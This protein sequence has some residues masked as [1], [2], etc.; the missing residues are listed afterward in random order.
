ME[1]IYVL[2]ISHD[3]IPSSSSFSVFTNNLKLE[4]DKNIE[5]ITKIS[6]SSNGYIEEIFKSLDELYGTVHVKINIR[7]DYVCS[8]N[9]MNFHVFEIDKYVYINLGKRLSKKDF[10]IEVEILDLDILFIEKKTINLY[11]LI[12]ACLY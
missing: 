12:I 10:N 7:F 2:G 3:Y 1:D 4:V 9:N 6:C 5:S 11:T 8:E